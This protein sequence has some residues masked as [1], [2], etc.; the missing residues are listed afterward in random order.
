MLPYAMQV[1]ELEKV[2]RLEAGHTTQR[3]ERPRLSEPKEFDDARCLVCSLAP[4]GWCEECRSVYYCRAEHQEVDARW[5][6]AVCE[7]LREI[8][9]DTAFR[10]RRSATELAS[11][12]LER[13][14]ERERDRTVLAGW[15]AYWGHESFGEPAE[16]RVLGDLASRPLTV[17]R[18]LDDL[19]VPP[20][21]Q[22]LVRIHVMGASEKELEAPALYAE[23]AAFRAES[24]FEIAL[25]GPQLPIVDVEPLERVCFTLHAREYRRELWSEIGRPD[26]I[27][28]FDAGLLIYRSWQATMLELFGSGVPLAITSYRAWEAKGEAE[29]LSSVGATCLRKPMRNPFFSQAWRRSHTVANDVSQDNSYVSVWL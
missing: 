3:N 22:K 2:A 11:R 13:A 24:S 4:S 5:H 17:A 21:G 29:L 9:D 25:V 14:G 23:L 15:D 10:E 20:T 16:R 8:L 7:R 28:A 1:A 26:L 18:L 12:L 6:D 19:K 27:V